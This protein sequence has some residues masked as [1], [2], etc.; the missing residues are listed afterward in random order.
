MKYLLIPAAIA[1]GLSACATVTRG[2]TNQIQFRSEPTGAR[3]VTSLNH[4]CTTPCTITVNRKEEFQ[5]VFTLPGYREG[6][7]E[8]KSQVAGA[9]VAGFAGNVLIGGVIAMGVDAATGSTLEHVPNPVVAILERETAPS[10]GRAGR[11]VA[12][13]EPRPVIQPAATEVPVEPPP[14]PRVPTEPLTRGIVPSST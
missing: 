3:V 9:G 10:R 1:V 6:R 8:V 13:A 2:T 5:A 12:R 4:E 11:P 7:I 14:A